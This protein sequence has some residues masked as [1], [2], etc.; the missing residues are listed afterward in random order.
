VNASC[1]LLALLLSVMTFYGVEKPLFR[2]RRHHKLS[3]VLVFLIL[4]VSLAATWLLVNSPLDMRRVVELNVMRDTPIKVSSAAECGLDAAHRPLLFHCVRQSS[5]E[6]PKYALIGDSKALAL[7]KG[8]FASSRVG[9]TWESLNG[10]YPHMQKDTAAQKDTHQKRLAGLSATLDYLTVN[11]AIKIVV[12]ANAARTFFS[13]DGY[14]EINLLNAVNYASVAAGL[15]D[16]VTKLIKA[17][18]KVVFVIDNPTLPNP[19]DCIDRVT[20][21]SFINR[22]LPDRSDSCQ[23]S[24]SHHLKVTRKYYQLLNELQSKFN[25]DVFIFDTLGFLC[26]LTKGFCYSL[27]GRQQLYSYTDHIS[28]YSAL[29]IGEELNKYLS[30]L[31]PD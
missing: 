11:N 21:I 3:I 24:I 1:L 27:K 17:D 16:T 10:V 23:V 18:K 30:E 14:D 25:H 7:Y 4:S 22:L 29:K 19:E 13:P 28:D 26:D 5:G 8:L 31:D 9:A 2:F 20:S 6:P 12:I 15:E